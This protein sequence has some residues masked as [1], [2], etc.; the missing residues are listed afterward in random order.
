ML[1]DGGAGVAGVADEAAAEGAPAEDL[2]MSLWGACQAVGLPD[3]V[4]GVGVA[5]RGT[6]DVVEERQPARDRFVRCTPVAGPRG[7]DRGAPSPP[8]CVVRVRAHARISS[9]GSARL[10]VGDDLGT[11]GG[12]TRQRFFGPGGPAGSP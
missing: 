4:G 9:T 7:G 8:V 5:A 10:A 12:P 6:A 2:A 3:D 11:G 1:R